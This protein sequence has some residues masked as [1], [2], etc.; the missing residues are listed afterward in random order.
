MS[1]LRWILVMASVALLAWIY[2]QGRRKRFAAT[3]Q[4]SVVSRREAEPPSVGLAHDDRERE[5]TITARDPNLVTDDLP[6][7]RVSGKAP[8]S[9]EQ[10][11]S[12]GALDRLTMT[13][14]LTAAA[15]PST[16]RVAPIIVDER[17]RPA[18][19]AKPDMSGGSRPTRKVIV[20]RVAAADHLFNGAR[21]QHAL[22]MQ[23]LRHGRYGIYH[24]SD[25]TGGT[26]F[27]VASMVEPGTFDLAT[28]SR[29][30]YPGVSLFLQLPASADG[31]VAFEAMLT[32]A[33][34]LQ[35]E[36]H[37]ALYGERGKPLTAEL[38]GSIRDDIANFQHLAP[39]L[40][41]SG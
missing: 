2:W 8:L 37:G 23:G 27:S 19:I 18:T 13:Q 22:A 30:E 5:P 7:V 34:A 14:P 15:P 20:L 17:P 35:Q 29:T 28:M 32:C 10:A 41:V 3:T 21:L 31:L 12:T 1:E 6:E 36:F 33:Q 25:A 40:T 4:D 9:I 39:P 26:L 38:I 11:L 16:Q 24:R